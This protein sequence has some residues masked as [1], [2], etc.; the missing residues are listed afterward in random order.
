MKKILCLICVLFSLTAAVFAASGE[1]TVTVPKGASVSLKKGFSSGSK[2]TEAKKETIDGATVYTYTDRTA[3]IYYVT[4]SGSGFY[5]QAQPLWYSPEAAVTGRNY[6]IDPGKRADGTFQQTSTV[7]LYTQETMD[8]LLP[9]DPALWPDYAHVFT[10]PWF[11]QVHAKNQQTTQD[12]MMACLR[13]LDGA[14]DN[15]YLFVIGK[16]PVYSYE[17]PVVLFSQ[18]DLSGA[19]TLAEAAALVTVNGKP[20]VQ[21]QAEIH[22]NEPAGGEACLAMIGALD[23]EYGKTVLSEINMICI[24]RI[25]T[26]GANKFQRHNVND[27]I[28]MNRDH[29]YL[30]SEEVTL[31]HS[32]YNLFR[33][34]VVFDGHEFTPND[35]EKESGPL[36]DVQLGI[37]RNLN[38]LPELGDTEEAMVNA[39]MAKLES[40]GL[41]PGIYGTY[42]STVTNATAR[43]FYGISGSLSFLVETRG[44]GS[45]MGWY[46]RRIVAQ[47][48]TMET[49]I[50]YVV[51]HAQEIRQMVASAR[52][53][54]VQQGKIYDESR[55][56]VLTHGVNKSTQSGITFTRPVANLITGQW[57][58]P[59]A[60][61]TYYRHNKAS[62]SR[63]LPTAYVIPKGEGWADTALKKMTANGLTYYELAPGESVWV[64]Q[65]QGTAEKATLNK[66]AAVTFPKGAYVFPMD[67]VGA[68]VLALYMEPDVTDS[69]EYKVS[70]VQ[71]GLVKGGG[72][73]PIYRCIR[74]LTAASRIPAAPKGDYIA[75]EEP[76]IPAARWS[77][78]TN[79]VDCATLEE[80]VKRITSDGLSVITLLEDVSA[81][82]S[83][84][85]DSPYT[86]TLDLNGHTAVTDTR[87]AI[88]IRAAGSKN[89]VTVIKNGTIT[90]GILGVR[91]D[92]GSLQLQNVTVR[93]GSAPAV[94]YYAT[95]SKYNAQNL[96]DN[97]TLIANDRATFSFHHASS[98]QKDMAF[99]IRDSRLI[100]YTAAG[101]EIIGARTT[102]GTVTLEGAVELYSAR[103][104]SVTDATT[105]L[106]GT[107]LTESAETGS[108]EVAALS[109]VYHK[110]YLR[111]TAVAEVPA[112]P[113]VPVTPEFPAA[114]EVPVTPE[115]TFD[116]E[117]FEPEV[118]EAP[119]P[120]TQPESPEAPEA[121]VTP[122]VP[123]EPEP[124]EDPASNA[125]LILGLVGGILVIAAVVLMTVRKKKK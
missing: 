20:T 47:Y 29:F 94:G 53:K 22:A 97:C 121:S 99:V 79:T 38:T 91:L 110:L 6:E 32:V 40:Q 117:V 68:M 55:K 41:R 112:A 95:D 65:Y 60:T 59:N 5:T 105:V 70:L 124:S 101:C 56:I 67:Q 104:G 37:S 98:S 81:G 34:E 74:D 14:E 113:E 116:P 23:G 42:Y 78:G 43:G 102:G 50:D 36:D 93:G 27:N 122:E 18:T 13:A 115:I 44:I 58:S 16:S 51:D 11:T 39:T 17:I 26:D 103:P 1:M 66:E 92:D 82:T 83:A 119:E 100:S 25:N 8:N 84:V 72:N 90:A 62:R 89:A 31:L 64:Q 48:I 77:D 12:E 2:V 61:A 114:P 107:P 88:W 87:N 4:V 35:R 125:G 69:K 111:T 80:A 3:G 28:D 123:T 76:F 52:E 108:V 73:L 49:Y 85:I 71:A 19:K 63:S 57:T 24:P 10:A 7:L 75:G 96:I 21:Y 15:M 120:S 54:L 109:A 46:P 9:S 45:G 118:P 106:L 30:Q 86:F 33:P